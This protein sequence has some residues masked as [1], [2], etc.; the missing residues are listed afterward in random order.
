MFKF[1]GFAFGVLFVIGLSDSTALAQE[2]VQSMLAAQIRTQGFTCDKTLGAK[3][4][5]KRSKADREVWVLRCSN[6]NYRVGRAPDM[7]AK[8]E[9]IR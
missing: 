6:A 4:D 9:V 5:A 2:T 1:T 7:A 8:V 3:K